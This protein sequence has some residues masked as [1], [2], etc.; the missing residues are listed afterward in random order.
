MPSS[1]APAFV[2]NTL[3]RLTPDDLGGVQGIRMFFWKRQ[4]FTRPLLR[5]PDE[6]L[7]C[8]APL[9]RS[10]TSDS[11]ALARTL[12]GNRTLYENNR[13]VGGVLYPFAAVELTQEDWRRH[14]RAQ[15]R[16]L[17]KAKRRYDPD[18]V[19]ASGPQLYFT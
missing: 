14:Y 10:P 18:A 1:A 3:P 7:I 17:A 8:Y 4:S 9:L 5:L 16:D 12:A 15:W 6:Q 11:Q 2:G 19:L 13:D